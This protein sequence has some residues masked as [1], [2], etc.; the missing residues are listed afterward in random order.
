M[1]PSVQ[2]CSN[3]GLTKSRRTS[4]TRTN[5]AAPF[6]RPLVSGGSRRQR[7][8]L[9]HVLHLREW[10]ERHEIWDHERKLHQV[11]DRLHWW[12]LHDNACDNAGDS[13]THCTCLGHL[14]QCDTERIVSIYVATP[15][16]AKANTI[17]V[18]VAGIIAG[19]IMLTFANRNRA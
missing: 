4:V 15:K 11:M 8:D 17:C 9:R 6:S 14:K 1:K 19:I 2:N 18:A 5:V 16:V 13:N 7:V 10:N 12:T 3:L